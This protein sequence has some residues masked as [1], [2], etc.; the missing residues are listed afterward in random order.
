MVF[1][2]EKE[3]ANLQME[4]SAALAATF[5]LAALPATN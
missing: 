3:H 1:G 2:K 4:T 5:F